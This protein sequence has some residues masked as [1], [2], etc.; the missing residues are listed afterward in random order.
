MDGDT[1][2]CE[3]KQTS[4]HT[5]MEG[6]WRAHVDHYSRIKTV[7]R[8]QVIISEESSDPGSVRSSDEQ[9][10]A[11]GTPSRQLGPAFSAVRVIQTSLEELQSL[12]V[13]I[14]RAR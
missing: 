5:G 1:A 11:S 6:Y 14:G 7:P 8:R 3:A 2:H 13:S 4:S 9:S 10:A 12:Q